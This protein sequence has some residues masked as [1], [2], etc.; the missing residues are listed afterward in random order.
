MK[1]IK[2]QIR[3]EGELKENNN[4]KMVAWKKI[5]YIL[6]HL[7]VPTPQ[8]RGAVFRVLKLL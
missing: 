8:K 1:L 5:P 6:T 7:F 2:A 3:E 4:N